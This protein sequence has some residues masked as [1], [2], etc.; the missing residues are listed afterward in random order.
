MVKKKVT[1]ALYWYIYFQNRLHVFYPLT[2]WK[3]R[4]FPVE[5]LEMQQ[6]ILCKGLILHV[7]SAKT[8]NIIY[9][10]NTFSHVSVNMG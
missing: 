2:I 3:M 8:T 10:E 9:Q 1:F 4:D 6:V 7:N 5:C